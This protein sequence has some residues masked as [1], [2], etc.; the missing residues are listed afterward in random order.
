MSNEPSPLFKESDF[1]AAEY[2]LAY[3]APSFE[4]LPEDIKDRFWDELEERENS[5]VGVPND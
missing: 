1:L 2:M 4:E 5:I 3:E